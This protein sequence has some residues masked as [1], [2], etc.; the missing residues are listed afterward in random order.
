[1]VLLEMVGF[2]LERCFCLLDLVL[3]LGVRVD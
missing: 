3:D 1:M 2:G